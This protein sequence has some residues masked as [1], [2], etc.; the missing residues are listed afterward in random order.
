MKRFQVMV[1]ELQDGPDG[2]PIGVPVATKEVSANSLE[3]ARERVRELAQHH[4]WNVRTIGL[5]TDGAF[6]VLIHQVKPRDR[7]KRVQGAVWK[8]GQRKPKQ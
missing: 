8:R 3:T 7:V 5:R 6:Q 4:G 2:K 1:V